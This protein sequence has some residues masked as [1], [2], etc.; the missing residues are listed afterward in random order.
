MSRYTLVIQ[1]DRKDVV[2]A[3]FAKLPSRYETAWVKPTVEGLAYYSEPVEGA[4]KARLPVGRLATLVP[5]PTPEGEEPTHFILSG[6][7]EDWQLKML[8]DAVRNTK[9]LKDMTWWDAEGEDGSQRLASSLKI[10]PVVE[11]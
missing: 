2:E 6:E 3:A 5:C 9:L 4:V 11:A 1:A 7:F 8:K 10:Q